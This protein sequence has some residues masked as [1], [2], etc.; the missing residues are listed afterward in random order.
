MD[1]FTA[2]WIAAA[3]AFL[4]G[5]RTYEMFAEYWSQV[6]DPSDPRATR[7]NGLPKYVVSTTLDRVPWNN[8]ILLRDD[9]AEEVAKLKR[10]PGNELQVHGSAT[11][12]RTLMK[13]GLIDEYRLLI[14][15][16]V[17]GNGQRLFA[18][19]TTPAALKLIDTK[20]TSRGVVAHIYQPSGKPE[21]GSAV[22]EQDG[23][24]VKDSV[25]RRQS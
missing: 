4:L 8:S 24:A 19:G 1:R 10:Q 14:H 20:T 16:V 11:L 2:D 3:D 25:S 15:P 12:I 6:T 7:L 13:H 23:D 9:V 22:P 21:Y 17:L 5:R 18:G